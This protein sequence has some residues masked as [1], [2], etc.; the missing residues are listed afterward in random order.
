MTY[1]CSEAFGHRHADDGVIVHA[2]AGEGLREGVTSVCD[3]VGVCRV[4][5]DDDDDD[6][7]VDDAEDVPEPQAPLLSDKGVWAHCRS[8]DE[9]QESRGCNMRQHWHNA[10]INGDGDDDGDG[11]GDG[12]EDDDDDDVTKKKIEKG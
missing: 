2:G 1:R 6:D 8:T 11:D 12:D 10:N 9:S 3:D 4:H 7:D 5:D